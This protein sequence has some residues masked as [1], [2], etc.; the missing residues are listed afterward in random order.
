MKQIL[1]AALFF[2]CL[3]GL[4]CEAAVPEPVDNYVNDFAELLTASQEQS[5]RSIASRLEQETGVELTLVLIDRVADHYD[6]DAIEPF[7]SQLFNDW[8]V[9]Q[10]GR[11]DG[12]LLLVALQDRAM[13][14]ELGAGYG[15]A[16]DATMQAIIDTELV[17]AFRKRDYAFGLLMAVESLAEFARNQHT[18][19]QSG[20]LA[21]QLLHRIQLTFHSPW[22]KVAALFGVGG[23]LW[24]WFRRWNRHRQRQCEQ[25]GARMVRLSEVLDDRYL[26]A[27][28]KMEERLGSVDYDVWKCT[29]CAHRMVIDYPALISRS[30]RCPQCNCRTSRQMSR[31]VLGDQ[32]TTRYHCRHCQHIEQVYSTVSESDARSEFGGGRS[33]GGGA[34]GR[35]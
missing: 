12:I 32:V 2:G 14:I 8:G 1:F 34:T 25:C 19:Q 11:D 6:S 26:D 33:G 18:R 5:L 7:A 29:G 28:Q 35:W 15:S 30:R 9:G 10:I 22:A 3:A 13:R 4:D 31:T 21:E 20:S 23:I 27:G 24:Q 16:N 17:P